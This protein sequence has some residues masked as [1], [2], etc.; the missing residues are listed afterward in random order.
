MTAMMKGTRRVILRMGVSC[1][2]QHRSRPTGRVLAECE[3]CERD[4]AKTK[5]P[6]RISA[7]A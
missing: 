3:L 6:S 2:C 5:M 1:E 4:Q 7:A